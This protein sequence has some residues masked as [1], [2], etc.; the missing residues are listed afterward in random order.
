[1]SSARGHTIRRRLQGVAFLV[2]L[3]ALLGLSVAFYNKTFADVATVTLKTDTAGNQL[4]EASDVKVRG[5]LVGEVREVRADF[6]GATIV[7]AINPQYLPRIPDNVTARL[8][9][10][11]LFG[12][13]FVS[14]VPPENPSS[15]PLASGAV[16][17]QD[18]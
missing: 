16:I 13:R 15:Q 3:A 5:V 8:L 12:E 1:M 17:G 11:T 7:L 14:L 2:V 18:R 10:K 6:D 9:P 4:K